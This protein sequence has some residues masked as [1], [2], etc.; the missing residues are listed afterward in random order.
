MI[1]LSRLIIENNLK[2]IKDFRGI[3]KV[4]QVRENNDWNT[5]QKKHSVHF[6]FDTSRH[7]NPLEIKEHG[8]IDF[9]Y[10]IPNENTYQSL[11]QYE[12][13]LVIANWSLAKE[14]NFEEWKNGEEH[15]TNKFTVSQV[16]GDIPTNP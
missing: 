13:K 2:K 8:G 15:P 6:C 3:V 14:T 1:K 16:L 12:G 5:G 11:K 4:H 9:V 7:L 10:N